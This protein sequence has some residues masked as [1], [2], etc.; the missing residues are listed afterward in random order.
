MRG[1]VAGKLQFEG[2]PT[3]FGTSNLSTRGYRSVP[4][5]RYLAVTLSFTT[6]SAHNSKECT[7]GAVSTPGASRIGCKKTCCGL[8]QGTCT[9]AQDHEKERERERKRSKVHTNAPD[10]QIL[11]QITRTQSR[12]DVEIPLRHDALAH[13]R[14]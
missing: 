8:V 1:D 11:R 5:S 14:H 3:N 9:T 12:C 4:R 7:T 6:T 2:K 13:P 10:R